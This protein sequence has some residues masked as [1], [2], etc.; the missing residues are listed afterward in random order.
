MSQESCKK[1]TAIRA[2]MKNGEWEKAFALAC[3]IGNRLRGERKNIEDGY[4]ALLYPHLI[5]L[6]GQNPTEAYERGVAALHRRY[7]PLKKK[8]Y[9][10]A[11]ERRSRRTW[12][13][14]REIRL[15]GDYEA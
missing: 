15:Y 11:A 12:R 8:R 9:I 5:E 6:I 4:Q 2:Y 10:T 3:T 14:L 1:A 7:P 13:T